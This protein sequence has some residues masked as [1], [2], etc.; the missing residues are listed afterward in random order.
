VLRWV[1]GQPQLSQPDASSRLPDA[2][3]VSANATFNS[4]PAANNSM[5]DTER[6]RRQYLI[7]HTFYIFSHQCLF[8]FLPYSIDDLRQAEKNVRTPNYSI[9]EPKSAPR[10]PRRPW[11]A[12]WEERFAPKEGWLMLKFSP[13]V[14][15]RLRLTLWDAWFTVNNII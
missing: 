2:T 3:S 13:Q 7:R 10:V 1:I 12:S 15:K 9:Y 14:P 11:L 6:K 8:I 5:Y 4:A